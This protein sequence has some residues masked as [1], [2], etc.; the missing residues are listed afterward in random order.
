MEKITIVLVDD[1][2]LFLEGLKT[3]LKAY[4]FIEIVATFNTANKA[5]RFLKKETI[6]LVITDISMPELNGIEFI[7]KLKK[8][9]STIKVIAI[10]MFKPVHFEENFYDGY[11]LKDAEI[12][13][14]VN[15]IK[16]VVYEDTS[17]FCPSITASNE[18]TFSNKIVTKREKEVIC[19]IAKEYTVDEI[20]DTLFLSRHTVETHKKNIFL[21]LQVKSNA[22]LIQKAIQLGVI[23]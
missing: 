13:T 2:T 17:Y 23:N 8:Q 5:L 15:A 12:K 16:S 1:H 20:A 7:K 10:S 21:K 19:L 9:D 22:G 14:V 18:L 11:L 3:A 4:N 6:D